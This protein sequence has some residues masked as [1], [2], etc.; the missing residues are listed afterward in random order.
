[1]TTGDLGKSPANEKVVRNALLESEARLR[2]IAMATND[3][4]FDWDFSTNE[5]WWNQNQEQARTFEAPAH[6][7]ITWWR[8]RVH[9]DDAAPLLAS[10]LAAYERKDPSWRAEY[11]FRRSDGRY[12]DM[13]VRG[14]VMYRDDGA[15]ARMVGAIT[16][17]TDRKKAE[18]DLESSL[19]FLRAA[20]EST[21]DGILVVGTGGDITL[22][23]AKF[24]E[25]WRVPDAVMATGDDERVLAF[26][27]D[28]LEDPATFIAKVHE[29]YCAPEAESSDVLLLKDG[30]VFER[31]SRPQQLGETIVGR[32][33]SFR[34]V[35]DRTRAE[36]QLRKTTALKQALLDNMLDSVF[37][38]DAKG[39]VFLMNK[40]A[41]DL[42]G[43]RTEGGLDVRE[44]T[45]ILSLR[46]ED[47]RR[48]EPE[49]SSL[50]RASRGEVV[51]ARDRIIESPGGHRRVLRMSASPI[52]DE[53]GNAVG[54][55]AVGRDVTQSVE[56][57]QLKDQFVRVAAHELKTPVTV[58]KSYA[59]LALRESLA[60]PP[61]LLKKLRALE[62]GADRIDD[63]VR[64]LLDISQLL[65]GPL[66]LAKDRLDLGELVEEVLNRVSASER[67]PV[68][69]R[70]EKS[71]TILGDR[72]RLVQVTAVL[73]DNAIRYSPAGGDVEVSL[74][75]DEREAVIVV[76]DHG[77]G[78]SSAKQAQIF[79]RFY[80]AH[81]GTA[82][83]Y[84][85]MGVGLY[86]SREIV[87]QHGGTMVFHSE[88]GR[89]SRF[90]F[91][92]PLVGGRLER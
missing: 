65:L 67:H 6:P 91:S 9:P 40:A 37:A 66:P 92:L 27:L 83:D 39:Q 85:G 30:R 73:L 76:E 75:A 88:E 13:V 19:S 24:C 86:I 44:L 82:Y 80:R 46:A 7:D 89:G 29:L 8:A 60:L 32:V 10:R 4:I 25:M 51:P 33:W 47:G 23:N 63:I 16:D 5:I 74:T 42:T 48:L 28:Q 72:E 34:D 61:P 36:A 56:L 64:K 69:E 58:M 84:G 71:V 41:Q 81:S 14:Y 52:R 79:E 90:S 35:T 26:V 53:A 38:C 55:V 87:K 12:A 31:F 49:E 77:I 18:R 50:A 68:H 21:A 22:H 3:I 78:I 59:Q 11:R 70:I 17:I 15:P 62:R 20:L 57:E 1:M 54:A 2:L 43:L 45:D